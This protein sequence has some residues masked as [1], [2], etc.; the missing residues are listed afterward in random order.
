M[1]TFRWLGNAGFHIEAEGH[2]F[3]LDPFPSAATGP[4][5]DQWDALL[6]ELGP[7]I[8]LVSHGHYDHAGDLPWLIRK[9]DAVVLCNDSVAARLLAHGVSRGRVIPASNGTRFLHEVFQV[10]AFAVPHARMEAREALR[11]LLRLGPAGLRAFLLMIRYPGGTHLSFRITVKGRPIQ[12][13]GSL[14]RPEAAL[15]RIVR[16][17]PAW[18]LLLPLQKHTGWIQRAVD[19]V[20]RLKP[21]F[22]IPHHFDD[23]LPPFSE[24]VEIEDALRLLD[25]AFPRMHVIKPQ[26]MEGIRLKPKED[27]R[28][29]AAEFGLGPFRGIGPQETP[30]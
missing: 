16:Q 30:P 21:Q 11:H 15:D 1:V 27:S 28:G 22:L 7:E 23:A 20:H 18:V 29:I 17:G 4:S 24:P 9:S 14:G 12:H 10:E 19:Y 8:I 5:R 26:I 2:R 3:L 6:K 13:L 25:K